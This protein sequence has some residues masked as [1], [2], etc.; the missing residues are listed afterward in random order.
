MPARKLDVF[1]RD[2]EA[3]EHAFNWASNQ[4]GD[5]LA[6]T[7]VFWLVGLPTEEQDYIYHNGY[8]SA[9]CQH[10][11]ADYLASQAPLA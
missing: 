1:L 7:F 6:A 2:H 5:D 4:Y 11:F 9:A 3:Q 8:L 10:G